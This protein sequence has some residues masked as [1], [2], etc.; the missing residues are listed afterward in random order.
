MIVVSVTYTV[1]KE[2]ANKNKELIERFLH[3]FKQLEPAS[4][5]YT[6]F[7]NPEGATFRHTSQYANKEI[8]QQI[9]TLPS[10]VHFQEQRD[11]NLIA[12]P[13]IELFHYVGASKEV[14]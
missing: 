10:F 13:K 11:K 12:E 4:F 7:E 5:L 1:N 6:V 14:L 2:Y 8:Q 3:D 9:L